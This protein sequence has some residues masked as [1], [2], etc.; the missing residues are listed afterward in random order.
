MHRESRLPPR[1]T[2]VVPQ[3]FTEPRNEDVSLD[4]RNA[5][6]SP[7]NILVDMVARLQQ[8]LVDIR[9]ES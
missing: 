1:G 7:E 6:W 5:P 2:Q 4:R 9:A 3:I 8:D